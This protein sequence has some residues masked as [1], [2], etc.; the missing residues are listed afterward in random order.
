MTSPTPS[1][2]HLGAWTELA[3]WP[4]GCPP[5]PTPEL[6]TRDPG[7]HERFSRQ[8]LILFAQLNPRAL[9]K[10][11]AAV[12]N[13]TRGVSSPP[14][15]VWPPRKSED[16]LLSGLLEP[17]N[18]WYAITKIAGLKT[19]RAYRREYGSNAIAAMPT[20]LYGPGDNFSLHSSHVLPSLSRKFT[21][22]ESAASLS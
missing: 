9:G 19:C 6:F 11:F 22:H 18:Q 1:G 15:V 10:L 16:C 2:P 20:N 14:A 17:T 7:R 12:N 21:M 13:P 3:M 8:V 4:S 5:V